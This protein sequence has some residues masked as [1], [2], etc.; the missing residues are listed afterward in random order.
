M[1]NPRWFIVSDYAGIEAGN[2]KFYYGYEVESPDGQWCFQMKRNDHI[3]TTIP[4]SELPQVRNQEDCAE[5][6]LAGL[7]FLFDTGILTSKTP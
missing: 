5:C 3:V 4:Y 7:T 6:L 2:L 1:T